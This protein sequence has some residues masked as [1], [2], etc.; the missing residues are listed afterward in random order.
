MNHKNQT[1]TLLCL[2]IAICFA[3]H[4]TS[5]IHR[6]AEKNRRVRFGWWRLDCRCFIAGAVREIGATFWFPEYENKC[7]SLWKHRYLAYPH[8]NQTLSSCP[9]TWGLHLQIKFL[10]H[11]RP[12]W[13]HIW[14][15]YLETVRVTVCLFISDFKLSFTPL[16]TSTHPWCHIQSIVSL[17]TLLH[18]LNSSVTEAVQSCGRALH[19]NYIL[20]WH[21]E[22]DVYHD[23]SPSPAAWWSDSSHIPK[24]FWD[25]ATA[26]SADKLTMPERAAADQSLVNKSEDS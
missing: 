21:R 19:W 23:S 14:L 20:L 22:R 12:S 18:I 15:E 16:A 4:G 6:R 13:N 10:P 17:P 2:C 3:P 8:T 1:L 26:T 7:L 5:S 11:S 25:S 9:G 24:H